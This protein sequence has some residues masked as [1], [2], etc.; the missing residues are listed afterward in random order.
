MKYVLFYKAP[1]ARNAPFQS[2]E[3]GQKIY[4][5]AISHCL[6]HWLIPAHVS[7][8]YIIYFNHN[9]IKWQSVEKYVMSLRDITTH[10]IYGTDIQQIVNKIKEISELINVRAEELGINDKEHLRQD[11][12]IVSLWRKL[13]I[14]HMRGLVMCEDMG[15]SDDSCMYIKEPQVC[16]TVL[17]VPK[18]ETCCG[19]FFG[20]DV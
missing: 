16:Q 14:L 7:K 5:R 3:E 19:R 8:F 17:G 9:F 10:H 2:P 12:E 20:L 11:H 1:Q 15:Y 18:E 4:A 6:Y 13:C